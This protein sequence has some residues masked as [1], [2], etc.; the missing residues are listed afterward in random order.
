VS[1]VPSQSRSGPRRRVGSFP[2]GRIAGIEIRVHWSFFLLVALFVLASTAPQGLGI[3][4]SL[5]WLVVIFACVLLHEL[6]HCLVGR[7]R[8]AVVHEIELLPIGGV[9]KLERLPEEPADEFAMAV[10]G[11]LA[12]VGIAGAAGL[13]AMLVQVSLLPFTLY[14]GSLLARTFWFNLVIAAFNLLPAF[15]LDGGRVFRA[16]LERRFD[17]L[18]ATRIAV[19]VGHAVAVALVV[20][21]LFFN[22]WFV[23]IGLFVYVGASAEEAATVVHV[24]LRNRRVDRVMLLDPVIVRTDTTAPSLQEMLRRV[25]QRAFPVVEDGHYVGMLDELGIRRAE[26]EARAGDL[27]VRGLALLDPSESV[28]DRLADL[29]GAPTRALAVG[30][31]DTIVGVLRIEDVEHL[32]RDELANKSRS[33]RNVAR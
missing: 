14:D 1:S 28:E 31:P 13:V 11:P 5:V 20:V 4:S 24:G 7:R 30:T 9:S 18:A 2:I 22:V 21:G 25:P 3:V 17:L 29:A 12:S 15:P 8:G 26:P 6:A 16:L 32:L 23:I 33:G 10:A 27:A 19:R